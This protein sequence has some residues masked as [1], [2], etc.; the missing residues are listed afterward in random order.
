MAFDPGVV[1][2]TREA[3]GLSQSAFGAILGVHWVTVSRWERDDG[4]E[5][6]P[7]Q[8]QLILHYKKAAQGRPRAARILGNILAEKGAIAGLRW[9]LN[10]AA[11]S[12]TTPPEA[13]PRT[14]R[15]T[16]GRRTSS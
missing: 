12:R 1:R 3:L 2:S 13:R 16:K 4:L 14:R 11:A 10:A 15:G 8:W 7:F 6:S 9:L 5:P